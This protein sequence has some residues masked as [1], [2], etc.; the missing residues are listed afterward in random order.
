MTDR[1]VR[2]GHSP[3]TAG[4]TWVI[5]AGGLLGRSLTASLGAQDPGA[6]MATQIRW[7]T[8]Y[9]RTD[10]SRGIDRLSDAVRVDRQPWRIAWCAGAGVIGTSAVDLDTEV[11]LLGTFLDELAVRSGRLGPG[12]VF[13]ASS[14][15][16]LYAG[17]TGGGPYTEVHPSAPISD[18]GRAKVACELA[19]RQYAT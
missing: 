9:A 7:S 19:V 1:P 6:V 2:A 10:L 15:G 3:R 12:T 17:G 18:Y 16:G 8:G 5:G 4:K 11:V 14:A 13:L